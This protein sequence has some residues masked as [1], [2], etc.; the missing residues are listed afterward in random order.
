MAKFK[1]KGGD[2]SP[3]IS[4]ASLPDIVFMLLFFFMVATVMRETDLKVD[5]DLPSANQIEKLERKDL[6]GYV[7]VGR[8][9][10]KLAASMGDAHRIQLQ[11]DFKEVKDVP[12]YVELVREGIRK[13]NEKEVGKMIIA[14]KVD[15][16]AKMKLIGDI[17]YKLR[18]SNAL[19]IN[20]S[21]NVGKNA[22]IE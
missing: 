12:E 16:E 4:T 2:D 13:R 21:T 14:L 7:Y 19:R 10:G 22:S 5:L 20:Y 9:S 15:A 11:D 6:V 1:K 17:K 3:G 8:P 18:E